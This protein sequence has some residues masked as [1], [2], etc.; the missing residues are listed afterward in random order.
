MTSSDAS[1]GTTSLSAEGKAEE[2][3]AANGNKE[4]EAP[5]KADE[6]KP[7]EDATETTEAADI[8]QGDAVVR[9]L[10]DQNT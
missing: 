8:S 5:P 1:N 6:P 9:L 10:K 4:V 2:G 7:A 3:K